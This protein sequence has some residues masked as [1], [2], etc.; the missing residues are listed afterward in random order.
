[1]VL[2]RSIGAGRGGDGRGVAEAF[3]LPRQAPVD[4]PR[5]DAGQLAAQGGG[6]VAVLAPLEAALEGD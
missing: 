5:E 1:M 2:V 4:R 6:Q 3:T